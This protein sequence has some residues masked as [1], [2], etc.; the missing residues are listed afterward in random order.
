MSLAELLAR[1]PGVIAVAAITLW[2]LLLALTAW[3]AIDSRSLDEYPAAPAVGA[4][5]V[6]VIVP[7]R[8]E[9]RNIARNVRSILAS[10]YPRL[11]LIVVDDHSTDGTG[12]IARAVGG[13]LA[14]DR[15]REAAREPAL[16]VMVPPPLPDGW[17]GKQWACH[18]GAL[19]AQGTLL[20]FTDADTTHG[21]ELLA[22]SVNAL[23]ARGSHLFTVGGEQEMSSFW[24]KV[25]QP[26]VF[27]TLFT[28]YGG[29][30]R[31]SRTARPRDKIANGQ[32]LLL[33]RDAYEAEGGHEAVRAHV[34]E[35]LRLAQL[36]TER[37][38]RVHMMLAR[39]HLSTRMY[40]SFAEIRRGW[41]K[42][43]FAAGR[44]SM[45]GPAALRALFPV[46]LPL[47]S[48]IA[49]IPLVVL[50]LALPGVLG[51]GAAWF[52][53][54]AGGAS[55]LYWMGVYRAAGL[56]PLWGLSFPLA[57]V[58]FA[59]IC[60][61]ASWRGSHVEWKGRAYVSRSP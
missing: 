60:A 61:E 41:G 17:F 22:R 9:A 48:L 34:A 11:E 32:F 43:V 47:S 52:G 24:E 35:D 1:P 30:E 27:A 39:D 51:G 38:R 56:S 14:R 50:A 13:A 4:P 15:T 2:V 16:R 23:E 42:N 40:G 36:W 44:D 54:V 7:A 26:Y 18:N 57:A 10:S 45:P 20:C 31:V 12:D 19:A 37:G 33:R 46:L 58:T 49:V 29:M 21:P 25:I 55:L 28:R 5:L 3:R 53:V 59:L 6:S 8:N